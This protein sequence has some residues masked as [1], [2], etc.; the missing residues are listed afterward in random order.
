MTITTTKWGCVRCPNPSGGRFDDRTFVFFC[1]DCNTNLQSGK[2]YNPDNLTEAQKQRSS[3]SSQLAKRKSRMK[4]IGLN[5]QPPSEGSA[6]IME[7][8]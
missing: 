3:R 7:S 8:E 5:T 1:P 4:K 2:P 6:Q